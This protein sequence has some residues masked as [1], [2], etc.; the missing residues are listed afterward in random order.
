MR[1]V[2]AVR[3]IPRMDDHPEFRRNAQWA[4]FCSRALCDYR[5]G[6]MISGVITNLRLRQ[7]YIHMKAM[8]GSV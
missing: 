8:A 7:L 1:M 3:T 5:I 4:Q 2:A 6:H